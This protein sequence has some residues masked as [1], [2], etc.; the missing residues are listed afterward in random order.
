[1]VKVLHD[2]SYTFNYVIISFYIYRIKDYYLKIKI[3]Q[4]KH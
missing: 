2:I 4:T 3:Y 1:M